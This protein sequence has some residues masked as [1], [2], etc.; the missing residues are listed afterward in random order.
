MIPHILT[1]IPTNHTQVTPIFIKF[2]FLF[3][4]CV[5]FILSESILKI[6]NLFSLGLGLELEGAFLKLLTMLDGEKSF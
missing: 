5:L 6:P 4:A 1:V 3:Q 2:H